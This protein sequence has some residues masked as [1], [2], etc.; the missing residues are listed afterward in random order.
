MCVV[1]ACVCASDESARHI[2][3]HATAYLWIQK[4]LQSNSTPFAISFMNRYGLV[5]P[6][7]SFILSVSS[8]VE[9]IHVTK[10]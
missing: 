10:S 2:N 7:P 3:T 6:P 8:G 9:K 4:Y 1:R 5:S